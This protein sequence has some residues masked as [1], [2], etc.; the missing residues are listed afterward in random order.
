M[1]EGCGRRRVGQ[2]VSRNVDSLKGRDR[3][4]LGGGDSFLQRTHLGRKGRLVTN[5]ASG[6]AEQ[7]RHLGASLRKTEDVVDEEQHILVLLVAEIFCNG[8][9]GKSHAQALAASPTE[10]DSEG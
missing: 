8:K 2:V 6:A 7:G 4:F 9:A 3:A 10:P 1:R 5:G